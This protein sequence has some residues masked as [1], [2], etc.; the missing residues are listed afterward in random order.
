[1]T[2]VFGALS[3]ILAL[4]EKENQEDRVEKQ[5]GMRSKD[6]LQLLSKSSVLQILIANSPHPLLFPL[7]WIHNFWKE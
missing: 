1:M 4:G 7:K 2:K 5:G 3:K 6:N